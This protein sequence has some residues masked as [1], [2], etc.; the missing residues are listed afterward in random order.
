MERAC[1]ALRALLECGLGRRWRVLLLLLSVIAR[2]LILNAALTLAVG[3]TPSRK[4]D[5]NRVPVDFTRQVRP[6]LSQHCFACHGPDRQAREAELSFVKFED[7]TA[8]RADGA[9]VTPGSRTSSRLWQRINDDESPMPPTEAHNAL[10]AE[11][12]ETLGRWIDEGASY[13]PHWAYVAPVA[14]AAPDVR[15][16]GWPRDDIDRHVLARLEAEGLAHAPDADPVTLVRR[17]TLDLAGLPPSSEEVDQFVDAYAIEPQA[18][19]AALLDR[20]LASHHYGERMATPW[21]DLVR[22]ADTVGYHGDQ[23]HNV[24]PYR[25]WVIDAFNDNMPFDQF[26]IEQLA[27]DLLPEPTQ[28]QLI[29]TGYNRLLQTTHEGGLQLAEY[30]AIYLAD[31]VRNA[32]AV[33]MGATLGCAQCHDHKYDP[34]SARDFYAFGAFFADIDDEEHL[35]NPYGG[36]NSSPTSRVPEMRVATDEVRRQ[37]AAMQSARAAAEAELAAALHALPAQQ[38]AW[39]AAMWQKIEAGAVRQIVWVEDALD[40]GGEVSGSWSFVDKGPRPHS[41][42]KT[43]VQRSKGLVQHYT[44]NTERRIEIAAGDVFYSWVHLAERS[45]PK[46]VMLQFFANGDWIHRAVWGSDDINYGRKPK[47][48]QGYHRMGALPASG[49]WVCLEVRAQDVGLKP[50]DVVAGWAFT[51]M[52]GTVHWDDAGVR[53]SVAPVEVVDALAIAPQQR[54]QAQRATIA[55]HHAKTADGVVAVRARLD[56]LDRSVQ[57][58]GKKMPSTLFTKALVQ[59]RLVKILPRGNWLDDSGPVVAPAIPAFLGKLPA[60]GRAS[61]LDLARWLVGREAGVAGLTARVFVNR[62]WAM[63]FGT[64]LC[65]SP[66]D[67]GGQGKPPNH[68]ALLDRLAIDFVDSGWDVKALVRRMVSSRV[69][70]QASMA[71]PG[72][73]ER[74]PLNELYA[75]QSRQRLPAE[76]VRDIALRVSGLLV[77]RVG[78]PSAKPPQP[79]GYYRHLNFPVRKYRADQDQDRWRRG[80]Y[81]HWQRQ[82]LH[83]MMRAFDAPTR[84]ECTAQRPISNTPLAALTLMNDPVFV[85]AARAFAQR[86]LQAR[87]ANDRDRIAWA[88]REATARVPRAAEVEV[89]RRL[90]VTGRQHFAKN[91]KAAEAL[92]AVGDSRRDASLTVIEHAAWTQVTRTML[93]LHET[94]S[95]D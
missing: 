9:A 30:R 67:F 64:A 81:V 57:E 82:F 39:E 52:G 72:V 1:Q 51:Q 43:R 73:V 42:K 94:I 47:S 36:L 55:K 4:P 65:P 25:E 33:W 78:G 23:E 45:Q 89:L 76:M 35:R 17:L 66:E 87:F 26:T 53:T 62:T 68:L 44:K 91:P 63:L 83:P 85:E 88:M 21:L 93:N 14:A 38:V 15:E 5:A 19:Y 7:A 41:G 3:Q 2:L 18:A 58:L 6:I 70:Q 34:Y 95:R 37:R 16:A 61:R 32:S 92:L 59:P 48:W 79:A 75:R 56:E 50:G 29:A 46:A 69:Y 8:K 22:Y 54:T 77:D 71:G 10:T 24:W 80:V 40:T 74:D 60:A 11:Q 90:L 20:L 49:Q 28:E 86:A 27:G 12:V 13:A 31:R 84:E